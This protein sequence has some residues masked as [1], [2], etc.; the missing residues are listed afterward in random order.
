M[1]S[2]MEKLK[3]WGIFSVGTVPGFEEMVTC[4]VMGSGIVIGIYAG[5]LRW[6]GGDVLLVSSGLSMGFASINLEFPR[7]GV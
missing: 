1:L 7:L 3:T 2:Q 6:A 4:T 5:V